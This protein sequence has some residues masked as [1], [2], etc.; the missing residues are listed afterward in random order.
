MSQQTLYRAPVTAQGQD[1]ADCRQYATYKE[2]KITVHVPD[3][4]ILRL[5]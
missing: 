5:S 4:N 1:T 2:N 3:N